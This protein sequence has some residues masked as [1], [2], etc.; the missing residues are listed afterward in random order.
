MGFLRAPSLRHCRTARDSSG[1]A[2]RTASYATTA[3]GWCDTATSAVPRT[4]FPV[5]GSRT[6]PRIP[7]TT[8]GSQWP[9]AAWRDGTVIAIGSRCF[10]TERTS[11]VHLQV[12]PSSRCSSMMRIVSGSAPGTRDSMSSTRIREKSSICVTIRCVRI[13]WS[14]IGSNHLREGPGG[15]SGSARN[16]GSTGSHRDRDP[17][18]IALRLRTCAMAHLMC[19]PSM[20]IRAARCGKESRMTGCCVVTTMA[21]SPDTIGTRQD[22]RA[23]LRTTTF[24]PSFRIVTAT[25][26]WVPRPGSICSIRRPGNSCT[27]VT[28]TAIPARSAVPT[29]CLFT[30]I[31]MGCCG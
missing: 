24:E 2:P 11:R 25:C 3:I 28:R 6:L 27:T 13:R 10:G 20:S 17:F 16:A 7:T 21:G 5:T 31:L 1:S 4:R 14:T 22:R 15:S 18:C 9:T 30:R 29:S 12:T 8:C 26:G 19:C 23:P